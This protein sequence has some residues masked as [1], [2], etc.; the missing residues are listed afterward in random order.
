MVE[1]VLKNIPSP[2]E[3][4]NKKSVLQ[5]TVPKHLRLDVVRDIL[6]AASFRVLNVTLASI[7]IEC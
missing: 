7:H 4:A 5:C 2:S 6:F 3:G 1:Y